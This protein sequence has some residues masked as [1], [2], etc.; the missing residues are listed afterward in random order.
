MNTKSKSTLEKLKQ[1][2]SFKTMDILNNKLRAL[3][4]KEPFGSLM[5]HGKIETRTWPTKI[6]G[7]VLICTSLQ[8]YNALQVRSITGS[9]L[10]DKISKLVG[11]NDRIC[12]H[13]IA[14]GNLVDCRPMKEEDEGK[15]FVKYYPGLYCH[16]YENVYPIIPLPWKGRLGW[17][18]V[19]EEFK[20][21]IKFIQ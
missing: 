2:L 13:A 9:E 7:Q 20:K 17:G 18:E 8:P 11:Y 6:R 4:W 10:F 3:S 19:P 12:G 5:L 16:V 14:I 15:C 21:L 1:E